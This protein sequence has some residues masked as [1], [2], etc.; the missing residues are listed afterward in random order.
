MKSPVKTLVLPVALL[1]FAISACQ[2]LL[3]GRTTDPEVAAIPEALRGSWGL[4]ENDCNPAFDPRKGLMVI[5][6]RTLAF[7]EA[8]ATLARVDSVT[9]T[10]LTGEFVFTGEGQTWTRQ[11]TFETQDSGMVLMRSDTGPDTGEGAQTGPYR[12]LN[13]EAV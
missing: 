7:Y 9:P 12:Y 5:E 11:I 6:G 8:R 2:P 1:A 4:N 13:C 3:T 10:S